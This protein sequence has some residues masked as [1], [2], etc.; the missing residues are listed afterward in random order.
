MRHVHIFPDSAIV[1]GVAPWVGWKESTAVGCVLI[2]YAHSPV[3]IMLAGKYFSRSAGRLRSTTRSDEKFKLP[4][5]V[6]MVSPRA[7][8]AENTPQRL[9]SSLAVA[10]SRRRI[11]LRRPYVLWPPEIRRNDSL[12]SSSV[13]RLSRFCID[14]L[15]PERIQ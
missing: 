3:P 8:A 6:R 9:P 4:Q 11:F 15:A 1:Y 7:L 14:P 12:T 13:Q 5:N 2:V 10:S